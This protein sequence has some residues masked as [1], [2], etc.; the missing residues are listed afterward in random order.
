MEF[1][2]VIE[3]EGSA[4]VELSLQTHSLVQLEVQHE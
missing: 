2:Y 4:E 3:V 1:L